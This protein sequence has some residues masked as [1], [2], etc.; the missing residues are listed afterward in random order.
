MCVCTCVHALWKAACPLYEC[1]VCLS[2]TWT[3]DHGTLCC[4]LGGST[5]EG[6]HALNVTTCVQTKEAVGPPR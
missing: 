5:T 6:V 1:D 3:A 2:K 4:M